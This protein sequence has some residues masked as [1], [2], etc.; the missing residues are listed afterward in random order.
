MFFNT[1]F[2]IRSAF[3]LFYGVGKSIPVFNGCEEKGTISMNALDLGNK[4]IERATP[5]TVL[6]N[7]TQF[8]KIKLK[9]IRTSVI[10]NLKNQVKLKLLNPVFTR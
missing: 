7:I 6:V 1:P 5:G 2:K 8:S 9:I 10:K 3:D 4:K